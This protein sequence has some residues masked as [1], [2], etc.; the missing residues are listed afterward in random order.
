MKRLKKL[1]L[2][3]MFVFLINNVGN[4]SAGDAEVLDTSKTVLGPWLYTCSGDEISYDLTLTL[5][6]ITINETHCSVSI[7]SDA[8]SSGMNYCSETTTIYYDINITYSTESHNFFG[9]TSNS[10]SSN[11][12]IHHWYL[13]SFQIKNEFLP[14]EIRIDY[15]ISY[16]NSESSI[17]KMNTATTI[18][19]DGSE[20]IPGPAISYVLGIGV[21]AG[22]MLWIVKRKRFNLI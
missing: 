19:S 2:L 12:P 20:N 5:E 16:N 10:A 17:R 18:L 22:L 6:L 7:V 11:N 9:N 21:I 13:K 3:F 1:V 15:D 8:E 4:A 14:A